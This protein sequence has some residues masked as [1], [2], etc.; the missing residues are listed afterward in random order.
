VSCPTCGAALPEGARCLACDVPEAPPP[1]PEPATPKRLLEGIA[2]TRWGSV[3]LLLAALGVYLG[4]QLGCGVVLVVAF[5]AERGNPSFTPEEFER[6][7]APWTPALMLATTA[8][9]VAL[10]ALLR[11]LGGLPSLAAEVASPRR[12]AAVVALAGLA[13]IGGQ[14]LISSAQSAAGLQPTEQQVLV[15]GLA[16]GGWLPVALT[17]VV[18]A[19][20]SEELLFRRLGYAVLSGPWGRGAAALSTT[21]LFG[22]VHLNPSATFLYVWLALCCTVAYEKTG[23]PLA[24]IAVHAANNSLA[25]AALLAS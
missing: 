21:L 1:P 18:L 25:V 6:W 23:R 4:V 8:A 14:M 2:R 19:P 11:R 5:I 10:V 15:E 16:S 20:L 3:L 24:P 7:M 17:L 9:I 12:T 22:L 13:C